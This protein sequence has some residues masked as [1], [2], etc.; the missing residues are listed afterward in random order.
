MKTTSEMKTSSN[1][2]MTHHKIDTKLE[3]Q[4]AVSAGNITGCE[5]NVCSI[6]HAHAHMFRKDDFLGKDN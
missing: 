2:L 6:G 1:L 3:M 4:S 5:R